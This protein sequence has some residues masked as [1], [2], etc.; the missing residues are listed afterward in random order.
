MKDGSGGWRYAKR[1]HKVSRNVTVDR[2]TPGHRFIDLDWVLTRRDR[3]SVLSFH[4]NEF[5]QKEG[6]QNCKY[7]V[8]VVRKKHLDFIERD[9]SFRKR[10]VYYKEY[11]KQFRL[12]KVSCHE[13]IKKQSICHGYRVNSFDRQVINNQLD[14]LVLQV[15]DASLSN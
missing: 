3:W 12:S 7:V 10:S 11:R 13:F 8:G 9:L 14:S 4:C 2:S 1:S 5:V 15:D 6:K